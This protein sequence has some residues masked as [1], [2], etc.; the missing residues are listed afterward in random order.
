MSPKT[1][2]I[3]NQRKICPLY[4]SQDEQTYVEKLIPHQSFAE[5]S[6]NGIELLVI[7]GE[8]LANGETYP[9]G[10]WIRLPIQNSH[11]FHACSAG[12][13]LYVKTGHLLSAQKFMEQK[14]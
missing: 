2:K 7:Q 6:A 1:G 10:S 13:I 8:L 5:H 3:L 14:P 4:D 12:A 9:A 11:N